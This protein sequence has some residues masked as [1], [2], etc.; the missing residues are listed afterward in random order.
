MSHR[1]RNAERSAVQ[2]RQAGELAKRKRVVK[3]MIACVTMFFLCYAPKALI[4][5]IS[6]AT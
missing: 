2:L 3:M 4:D 6:I 5:S 1:N